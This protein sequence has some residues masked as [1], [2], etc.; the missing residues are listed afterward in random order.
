MAE[1]RTLTCRDC[2]KPFTFTAGEQAFF[3]EKGLSDPIRCPDCRRLRKQQ[4]MADT[5][6]AAPPRTDFGPRSTGPRPGAESRPAGGFDRNA[7]PTRTAD[8]PPR[9]PRAEE[10]D[11]DQARGFRK[12][13]PPA[14]VTARYGPPKREQA[15]V[16]K[17]KRPNNRRNEE[18]LL[19][20]W[21]EEVGLNDQPDESDWLA[22]GDEEA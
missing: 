18:K 22:L 14:S 2:G 6:A 16:P 10:T 21:K 8:F 12:A 3:A 20:N 7:T 4:R 17:E 1:D 5:G 9:T 13:R 11:D 19:L 15:P